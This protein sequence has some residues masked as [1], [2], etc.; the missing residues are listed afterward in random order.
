M[1]TEKETVFLGKMSEE[2]G[3]GRK[4]ILK[5]ECTKCNE[6]QRKIQREIIKSV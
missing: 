1:T 5:V 2:E 4:V 6:R 3:L